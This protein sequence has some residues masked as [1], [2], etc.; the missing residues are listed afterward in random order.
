MVQGCQNM[1]EIKK[2]HKF[3]FGIN[4]LSLI[5]NDNRYFLYIKKLILFPNKRNFSDIPII[6]TCSTRLL[7]SCVVKN[8]AF[9]RL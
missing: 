1:T 3:F 9:I 5:C 6:I 4:N 8:G 2:Q 7:V